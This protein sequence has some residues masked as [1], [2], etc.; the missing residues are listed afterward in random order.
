[1]TARISGASASTHR[2]LAIDHCALR[3]GRGALE[4]VGRRASER[5]E[6]DAAPREGLG[7]EPGELEHSVDERG[8]AIGRASN[9]LEKIRFLGIEPHPDALV[10]QRREASD[11]AQGRA[12][13]VRDG[14]AER[15]ELAMG[16][17]RARP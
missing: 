1:M 14:I 9:A 10:Q 2:P 11:R 4:L 17:L 12:Q 13:V 5:T 15:L 16:P 3:S 7:R 6:V 8:H